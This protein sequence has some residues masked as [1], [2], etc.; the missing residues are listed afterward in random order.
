MRGG[1]SHRIHGAPSS[2]VAPKPMPSVIVPSIV[3]HGGARGVM[4]GMGQKTVWVGDEAIAKRGMLRM[5]YPMERGI[6]QNWYGSLSPPP[7]TSY[8][9]NTLVNNLLYREDMEALWHQVFYN[10]LRVAPEEHAVLVTESPANP[11]AN[12]ERTIQCMFETFNVPAMYLANTAVLSLY[13][14]GRTTGI[15]LDSGASSTSV[16]PICEGHAVAHGII[17]STHYNKDEYNGPMGVCGHNASDYLEKLLGTRI[18][19]QGQTHF[20]WNER[21]HVRQIKEKLCNEVSLSP[22]PLPLSLSL[23]L[24]S[25]NDSKSARTAAATSTSTT[26]NSLA[27]ELPG[28]YL[29]LRRESSKSTSL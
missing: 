21:D 23:S 15:V 20:T 13:A 27:Y 10:G 9:Y 17:H 24:T 11:S 14:T 22:L 28:I 25:S 12:R 1:L 26:T 18:N 2:S 29:C 19:P 4:V 6:V 5:K 16:V 7:L 8:P 3:G